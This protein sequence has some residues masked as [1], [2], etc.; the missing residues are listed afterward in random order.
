MF[1]N[2]DLFQHF[3]QKHKSSFL[4]KHIRM[5]DIDFEFGVS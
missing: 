4:R 2:V 1:P 5:K 3:F